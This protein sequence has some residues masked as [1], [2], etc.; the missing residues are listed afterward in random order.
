LSD[1]CKQVDSQAEFEPSCTPEWFKSACTIRLRC[2]VPESGERWL[3]R[4]RQLVL[5]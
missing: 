4:Y 2:R 1:D 5:R 3:A